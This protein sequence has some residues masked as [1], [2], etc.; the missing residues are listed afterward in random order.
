M[1]PRVLKLFACLKDEF[2][3]AKDELERLDSVGGDGDLGIVLR[4]GFEKVYEF[5]QTLTIEDTGKILFQ[6]GKKLNQVASS[7]MGTLLSNG[8]I[9]AGK[10]LKGKDSFESDDLVVFVS[11][12]CQGIQNLGHAQEGEKTILDAIFPASRAMMENKDKSE[13]EMVQ[14]GIAAAKDGIEKATQMIAKQ[15][16]LAYRQEASIGVVDPGTVAAYHLLMALYKA[17]D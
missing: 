15:G 17:I 3:Q 6:A 9:T 2:A 13:K 1:N 10:Q 5:V 4:D 12:I 14:K 16:R 8:F 11:S 7:S